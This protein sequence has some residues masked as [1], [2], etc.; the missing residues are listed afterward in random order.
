MFQS[1]SRDGPTAS[2]IAFSGV[3]VLVSLLFRNIKKAGAV[4]MSLFLGISWLIGLT[5]AFKIKINFL[6]FIAFPIT[7]GIGVDYGVNI[8]QRY[9]EEGRGS[10]LR[11]VRSTGAAVALCS[12]TTIIGYCSL[13][14]ARNLAFF[15]FGLLAVLGE[16]TCLS[17]AL[18]SVPSFIFLRDKSWLAARETPVITEEKRAA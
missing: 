16:V 12:S 14:F 13:L 4:L 17:A 18:I 10:I 3:V 11:V 9:H 6:N 2:L 8:I 7:F 5:L 1:I 15:S